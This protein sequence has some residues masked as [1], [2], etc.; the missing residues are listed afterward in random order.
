[1]YRGYK[2]RNAKLDSMVPPPYLAN[3]KTQLAANSFADLDSVSEIRQVL[4]FMHAQF[5]LLDRVVMA[6]VKHSKHFFPEQLDYG[7]KAFVDKLVQQRHTVENALN[8]LVKRYQQVAYHN[9]KW[10]QWVA[11]RQKEQDASEEKLKK[12]VK[13][14][15]AMFRRHLRQVE[16]R[17]DRRRVKER[18]RRQDADLERAFQERLT[19]ADVSD[20]DDPIDNLVDDSRSRY[21][22]LIMHFLWM[23]D[24]D[25][26]EESPVMDFEETAE[27]LAQQL[28][29]GG[30]K[31]QKKSKSKSKSKK[32]KPKD[33][34]TVPDQTED[35]TK[36]AVKASSSTMS[37]A[38]S[39]KGSVTPAVASQT[40]PE[41]DKTKIETRAA[42]RD[43][44]RH[45][46]DKDFSSM[47]GPQ[48][49]GTY[50]E[51]YE[52]RN[53][54]APIPEEEIRTLLGEITEVKRLL[55]CRLLL[56]HSS[57]LPIALQSSTI[58][59]FLANQ[60][61]TEADLRDICLRLEDPS[62]QD[63]RDACADLMREDDQPEEDRP[64]L[65]NT[66]SGFGGGERSNGQEDDDGQDAY[67]P[68]LDPDD[69]GAVDFGAVDDTK[70]Q[71]QRI[72][73]TV[74]GKTIWNYAS[75]KAMSRDGWL[76]FSIM[77]KDARLDESVQLCRHWDEFS[78]LNNLALW[79]FFPAAKWTSWA[80]HQ[81]NRQL[82]EK[83]FIP[84]WTSFDYGDENY[85]NEFISRGSMATISGNGPRL[86]RSNPHL[87]QR[88]F[89]CGH[90]KRNDPITRRFIQTF[91]TN[92]GDCLI[93]VR[94][95]KTGRIITAPPEEERWIIR[96]RPK[97]LSSY[98]D[99]GY[100]D[101]LRL[102]E[103][104]FKAA[105]DQRSWR[106]GFKEYY[107]IVIWDRVPN[108]PAM[109]IYNL[110][111]TVSVQDF[112]GEDRAD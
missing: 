66:D 79:N 96:E 61:V 9:E 78:D 48:V 52:L 1:M 81:Y 55:F 42:M 15:A 50:Q 84:Y 29:A 20:A 21:I 26:D 24:Q 63:I 47:T 100:V 11:E 14:E 85:G 67:D 44:L 57:L 82:L 112:H 40:T 72:K 80:G 105:E 60:D 43:R 65:G 94:D 92:T 58:E 33:Q 99:G 36:A 98:G 102:N 95:A 18:K 2:R 74:C 70:P 111:C 34:N 39:S 5:S 31:N 109:G 37:K 64:R 23:D 28:A 13:L 76:Q 32:K 101:K 7:H 16:E 3:A 69:F 68:T 53:K 25:G 41:P 88:N 51:P 106:F 27:T 89:I 93:F 73:V 86:Y 75:E 90:M 12:K 59:E 56:S 6:R 30:G 35:H 77:A 103:S 10:F 45:G 104:F 54:T 83:G 46:V 4:E 97:S 38:V 71:Q 91:V 108:R 62:V 19:L 87:E 8:R 17:L 22:E 107:D 110:I 49:L